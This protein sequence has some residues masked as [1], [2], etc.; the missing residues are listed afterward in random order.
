M[1]KLTVDF[2]TPIVANKT[3]PPLQ[4]VEGSMPYSL[5]NAVIPGTSK[6][7]IRHEL[8]QTDPAVQFGSYRAE[9][10]VMNNNSNPDANTP[11]LSFCTFIKSG[12]LNT[13]SKEVIFPFQFHDR[14]KTRG[15]GIASPSLAIEIMNGRYR[16]RIRYSVG[17]YHTS[18]NRRD[19][20]PIDLGPVVLDT[21]QTWLV[22]Y[23][24]HITAGKIRI[25]LNGAAESKPSFSYDG[26]CQFD[27]SQHPFLKMGIYGWNRPPLVGHKAVYLIT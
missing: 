9:M 14:S 26:P 3:Y 25:W 8:R 6:K 10:T 13:G 12:E 7:A 1:K 2:S 21:L 23:V 15:T 5:T 4:L 16:V 22:Y 20:A 11:W 24:P 18:G 27:G 17:D 19:V